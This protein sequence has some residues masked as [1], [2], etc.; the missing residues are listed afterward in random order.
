MNQERI[1]RSVHIRKQI[2]NKWIGWPAHANKSGMDEFLYWVLFGKQQMFS[3]LRLKG[4]CSGLH[5]ESE[6]IPYAAR[7]KVNKSFELI[8]LVNWF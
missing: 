2:Q 3:P 1:C 8:V 4:T 7:A 6:S 5:D